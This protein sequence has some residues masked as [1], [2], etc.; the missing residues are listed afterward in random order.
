MY[1]GQQVRGSG[2]PRR[3]GTAWG[4]GGWEE[5]LIC[6]KSGLSLPIYPSLSQLHPEGKDPPTHPPP[7]PQ[8]PL[9]AGSNSQ[10]RPTTLIGPLSLLLLRVDVLLRSGLDLLHPGS[11]GGSRAQLLGSFPHTSQVN[12]EPKPGT[13]LL[14]LANLG[15]NKFPITGLVFAQLKDSFAN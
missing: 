11:P 4:V 8:G 6:S 12:Q 13:P 1:W 5:Q 15:L 7:T 3:F 14:S 2:R 9:V 10:G